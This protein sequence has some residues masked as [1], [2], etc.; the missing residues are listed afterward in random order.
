LKCP[1]REAAFIN[2]LAQLFSTKN[3]AHEAAQRFSTNERKMPTARRAAL[4]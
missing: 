3:L 1:S 4:P 2:T